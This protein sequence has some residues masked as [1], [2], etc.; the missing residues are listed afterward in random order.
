M[1]GVHD[2]HRVE[3]EADGPRLDVSHARQQERREQ[4]AIAQPALH[5]RAHLPDHPLPRRLLQHAHER[6]YPG[7][8][9]DRPRIE[10]SLR[11]RDAREQSEKTEIAQRRE[12]TGTGGGL[13]ERAARDHGEAE[14][15]VTATPGTTQG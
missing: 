5:P 13:E 14:C 7:V 2:E 9:A 15:P 4:F 10:R 12:R 11:R 1:R 3:F 8:K 6:L